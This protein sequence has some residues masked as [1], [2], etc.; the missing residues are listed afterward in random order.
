M[1][2]LA[3]PLL[4]L[5][6]VG[7]GFGAISAAGDPA[8]YRR[9]LLPGVLGMVILFSAM[10]G[11]LSTV[12]DREFGGIR[13]LLIAPLRRSTIV[14]AKIASSTLVALAQSALLLPL[15]PVLGLRPGPG[16]IAILLAAMILTALALSALGM[17]LAARIESIESFSGVV[18]FVVLPMFFLSGALY[19]THGLPQVL[20]AL[21]AVNPLT[22]GVDLMKHALFGGASAGVLG[23]VRAVAGVPAGFAPELSPVL[24]V[25]ALTAA[26]VVSVAV[27]VPLFGREP[28]ATRAVAA[29]TA[30]R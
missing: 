28:S 23:G 20:R 16:R 6:V 17:L 18:N 29:P 14:L 12:H 9:F 21:A 13:L 19:P 27:T 26:F 22:Y 25:A 2:G 1:A 8:A 7:S 30:S 5:F 15:L 10:F 4:W 11:A 3:R 24:D